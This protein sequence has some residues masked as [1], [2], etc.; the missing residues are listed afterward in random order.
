MQA[1]SAFPDHYPYTVLMA[2]RS[3]PHP[4]GQRMAKLRQEHGLSQALLGQQLGVSR[5][6]IAYYESCAKNPT[7]EFIEKVAERFDVPASSLIGP[8]DQTP[9][10]KKPGPTPRLQQLTEQLARLPKTKQQV[11]VEML[12]GFLQ[13][14]SS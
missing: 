2:Q 10:K 3:Q 7:A 11:V 8:N 12:E 9:R 4:F 14:T 6:M 5:G 13:K 1:L